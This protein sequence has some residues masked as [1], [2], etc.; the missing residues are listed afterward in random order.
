MTTLVETPFST[1]R[2][3]VQAP[4]PARAATEIREDRHSRE[5]NIGLDAFC[6]RLNVALYD[7]GLSGAVGR[8]W[9]VP[10]GDG[11][12]TAPLSLRAADRL[13]RELEDLTRDEP[14]PWTIE[15]PLSQDG[16]Q[17]LSLF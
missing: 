12:A 1:P 7:L 14:Q 5:A 15:A 8:N 16:P 6:R 13:L 2:T 4:A 11:V 17:Q 9:F 10:A 3:L